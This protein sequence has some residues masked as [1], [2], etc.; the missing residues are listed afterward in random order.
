MNFDMPGQ[1][2]TATID[3]LLAASAIDLDKSNIFFMIDHS[4]VLTNKFHFEEL[5]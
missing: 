4:I 1:D 5:D 2:P 3:Q